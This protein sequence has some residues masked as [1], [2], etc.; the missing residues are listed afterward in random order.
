MDEAAHS[1]FSRESLARNFSAQHM[2]VDP[3]SPG[4][5]SAAT[6]GQKVFDHVPPWRSPLHAERRDTPRPTVA[7][8]IA[9]IIATVALIGSA[10]TARAQDVA[11]GEQ[12]FKKCLP[13]HAVG[14]G[15][16]N[17]IGPALNG[18]EGRKAGTIEDYSYTEANKNSGFSWDAASF[19]DYIKDPPAKVPGTKMMFPGI[20]NEKEADDLWAYI[21]RFGPDGKPK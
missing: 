18:L 14:E 8:T 12:S 15:A 1:L 2:R 4:A 20:K 9:A 10:A 16:K 17:K 6:A 11:A 13:C 19:K 5:A 3:G 7:G 21:R